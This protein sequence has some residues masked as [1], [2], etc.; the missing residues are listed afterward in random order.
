MPTETEDCT[1]VPR[2]S[3]MCV[4]VPYLPQHT[5]H[6]S[7]AC[8]LAL[9]TQRGDARGRPW[10]DVPNGILIGSNLV[11]MNC[12]TTASLWENCAP[13]YGSIGAHTLQPLFPLRRGRLPSN[14]NKRTNQTQTFDG[15]R[16]SCV[17]R[18]VDN[19]HICQICHSAP[20]ALAPSRASILSSQAQPMYRLPANGLKTH[21]TEESNPPSSTSVAMLRETA[22]LHRLASMQLISTDLLEAVLHCYVDTSIPVKQ[23]VCPCKH[24]STAIQGETA[25]L[26]KLAAMHLISTDLLEAVLHC[27]VDTSIP[28]KQHVCP[29]KKLHQKAK[30]ANRCAKFMRAASIIA[31]TIKAPTRK[32]TTNSILLLLARAAKHIH[33]LPAK[34]KV[35]RAALHKVRKSCFYAHIHAAA[36]PTPYVAP[37]KSTFPPGRGNLWQ[38]FLKFQHLSN[39]TGS[40]SD[41]MQQIDEEQTKK[42]MHALPNTNTIVN[43]KDMVNLGMPNSHNDIY[44]EQQGSSN[45]CQV[46]AINNVF[47][48]CIV[49]PESLINFMY[50]QYRNDPRFQGWLH[51]YEP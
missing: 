10:E 18:P 36:P 17:L 15:P 31:A 7:Y 32:A 33:G 50:K 14:E 3:S 11:C 46:H 24:A 38:N 4:D 37:K 29:C 9:R 2:C 43:N 22:F 47:G 48:A 30:S 13:R 8:T 23:H 49:I 20:R 12:A 26:H 25:F 28:V 45:H 41:K 6:A 44:F 35:A 21:Q 34:R 51:T 42:A 27:Y 40:C 1:A 5:V 19:T 39:F 16:Q